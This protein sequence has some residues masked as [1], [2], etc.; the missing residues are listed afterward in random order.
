MGIRL[1]SEAEAREDATEVAAAGLEQ[2]I[3]DLLANGW[4][5][6]DFAQA[7]ERIIEEN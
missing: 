3:V 7:V 6:E 5:R 1:L 4:T 2:A